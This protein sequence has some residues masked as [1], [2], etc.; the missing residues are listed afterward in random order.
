M[1]SEFEQDLQRVRDDLAAA[2]AELLA[3]VTSLSDAD[4]EKA[5][6]GGWTVR[7]VLEH[8]VWS[9]TMYS[10]LLQHLRGQQPASD[11]VEAT[12]A[13]V[14]DAVDRLGASH[15]A[16]VEGFDGVDEESFYRL[17]TVGHEEYSILSMIE[18]ESMHERE[19]ATQVQWILSV[20]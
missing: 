14:A 17:A 12:P 5:R 10:R 6:R 2:R 19:H 4:L 16:F 3:A 20:T 1:T 11:A 15:A 13:S 7:R 8:V 18:N 9:E